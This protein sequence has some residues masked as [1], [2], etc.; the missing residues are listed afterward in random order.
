M[1]AL[2]RD[3]SLDEIGKRLRGEGLTPHERI[4]AVDDAARVQWVVG[5]V[6][7][8]GWF[9][10]IIDVGSSDGTIARRFLDMGRRVYLIEPHEA[11]REALARLG[12]WTFF[13]TAR[14]A[15]YRM[16]WPSNGPD[17]R[18]LAYCGEVLEHLSQDDGYEIT[19]RLHARCASRLIVT[20][21][22]C[23]S[24]TYDQQGRG[25]WDWPDH[26]RTF[27]AES[28]LAWLTKSFWNVE[29]IDPIVGTLEDSIWLGAVCRRV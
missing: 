12:C 25:R 28:L 29:R 2:T 18:T 26:K 9:D 10:T 17:D 23:H 16:A 24:A 27:T 14:Q 13:G 21:P 3:Y 4:L 19:M 15:L 7:E 1:E 5:T 11:H 22:N 6:G 8:L 20:V